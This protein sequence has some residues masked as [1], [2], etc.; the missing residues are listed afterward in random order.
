MALLKLTALVELCRSSISSPFSVADPAANPT[1][2]NKPAWDTREHVPYPSLQLAAVASW[3]I[4]RCTVYL[5]V[6][7]IRSLGFS[8]CCVSPVRNSCD[9]PVA[10]RLV[11]TAHVAENVWQ[12]ELLFCTFLSDRWFLVEAGVEIPHSSYR[13]TWPHL[14]ALI[15]IIVLRN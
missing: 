9:L 11:A 15:I 8:L 13:E 3:C 6:R 14:L 12:G 5:V 2:G 1:E 10:A 7:K 4:T